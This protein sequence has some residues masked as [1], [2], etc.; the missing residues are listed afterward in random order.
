[1]KNLSRLLFV[2]VL[3]AS[4]STANAQDKNNPWAFGLGINAVDPYPV[5]EPLPQGE[6]FDEFLNANDHYNVL[7]FLSRLTVSRYLDDGFTFT[8][9][10]S[11]NRINKF[12]D[13]VDAFGNET[14]NRVPDLTYYAVDGTVSYSFMNLIKSN[15]IDPYLGVGGGYT[16]LDNTGA[17]TLNGTLGLSYWVSD[18]VAL[19]LQTSYKHSFEDNLPKHFQHAFGVKFK[20]GGPDSD[21]DGVIDS[22]DDCPTV[23]GLKALNGCP[24]ADGDGIADAKDGCPNEAGPAANN[25]CPWPDTDGDGVLDKDDTCPDVAGTVA[26][27]GCPE[28]TEEVQ[29]KLNAY[30]KTIL[31]DT[32]KDSIKDESKQ[33]LEDIIAILNKY[34]T[35]K[36]TVDGHTDSVGSEKL[37]LRLSDARAI[38]VKDYLVANGVDEFR[39]S[40][41][42]FGETKPIASNK[43]RD[44][45]AQ[46]RRVEINLAKD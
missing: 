41:D 35:S 46:N 36:F 13:N 11:L 21:G 45:R 14:T 28:V 18:K 43:T 31:F 32:G 19:D 27:N 15:T 5:G 26:N 9:A 16:W 34:P 4:F 12:G 39:L 24:D 29:N 37:N 1:M 23:A 6:F 22:K 3:L 8:V 7:P 33:V 42:G 2:A 40:A 38:S 25:G 20:F 10:G 44:G 17:G 30:A